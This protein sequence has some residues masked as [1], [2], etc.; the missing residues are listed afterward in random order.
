MEGRTGQLDFGTVTEHKENNKTG[1]TQIPELNEG[2][3]RKE[4]SRA[5]PFVSL[6]AKL[7]KKRLAN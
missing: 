3:R 5:S 6:V 2:I 4:N 7:L 1:I